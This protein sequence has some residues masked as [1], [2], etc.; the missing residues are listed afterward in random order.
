MDGHST[1]DVDQQD[2][3]NWCGQGSHLLPTVA[4]SKI[5]ASGAGFIRGWRSWPRVPGLFSQSL[6]QFGRST[7]LPVY[8]FAEGSALV[9]QLSALWSCL[10]RVLAGN[11]IFFAR[12]RACGHAC[13]V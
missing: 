4:F 12:V 7:Q 6:G 2:V 1:P 3:D 13:H 8:S 10:S 11:A 5:M 9:P